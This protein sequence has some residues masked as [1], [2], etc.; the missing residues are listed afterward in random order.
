MDRRMFF[1]DRRFDDKQIDYGQVL[2]TK[3]EEIV[4]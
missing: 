3:N 4:W 2:F 1:D